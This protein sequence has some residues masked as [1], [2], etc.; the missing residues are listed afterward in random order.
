MSD[1]QF[2][3]LLALLS[4]LSFAFGSVFVAKGA[5]GGGDRGVL[6]S[7]FVTM[8][9]S[10]VLWL[11]LESGGIGE[12]GNA[13]WWQ[14]IAWFALAGILAMV[15]GR[16]LVYTSIRYLGVTRSSSVKR[17][18]PF[19]S[20]ILAF[21]FLA[22]PI[23]GLDLVGMFLIAAAFGLLIYSN[24][25]HNHVSL[26]HNEK[27]SPIHYSWGVGSALAY[28]FAYIARKHGIDAT[29]MPVFGTMVSAATG[30]VF[31][32]IAA[33]FSKTWFDNLRRIFSNLNLW[34]TLAAIFVS[35]GQ[36]L[37]FS[38]LY[39]E[40]VSTVVMINSMEIFI[41]SF[42][43]VVI[44]RSERRPDM[45]TYLGAVIATVGVIAVAAG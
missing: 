15:F 35:M 14:G 41:A 39:Y 27:L 34:L 9:F 2:G 32:M 20:V 25:N 12:Y 45:G 24:T 33:V 28:A 5:K 44:F 23:T 16:T 8:V 4:A 21:I 37:Q 36:I 22:E 7:I 19:F 18:N 40:K 38:A 42:L 1:P 13:R 30:F 3:Q 10:F 43:S 31:F 17:L 26:P 11:L 29:D 6:F